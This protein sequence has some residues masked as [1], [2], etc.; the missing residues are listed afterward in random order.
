[1]K[2]PST[3][4]G[5]IPP[6]CAFFSNLLQLSHHPFLKG[7]LSAQIRGE[8]GR[9]ALNQM[10]YSYPDSPT[11]LYAKSGLFLR[12]LKTYS[13]HTPAPIAVTC[14]ML[15]RGAFP[16]TLKM[17]KTYFIVYGFPQRT[18]GMYRGVRILRVSFSCPFSQKYISLRS[19]VKFVKYISLGSTKYKAH[20]KSV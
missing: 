12:L 7:I 3:F 20:F 6:S 16:H 19:F 9:G 4:L 10:F 1:M 5:N 17:F 11:L 15:S 18:L 8:N 14:G 2:L 13:F